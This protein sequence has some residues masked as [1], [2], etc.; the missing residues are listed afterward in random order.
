MAA[1]KATRPYMPGYG[2]PKGKK[3]LLPWSWAKQRL[4]TS[5]NYWVATT[6]PDGA[7]HVMVVWGLWLDGLFL[8]STGRQ[9][10]KARN[11]ARNR[12]CVICNE[13]A[14]Q[15]VVVEGIA[16]RVREHSRLRKFLSLYETKYNWDMSAF[17][18]DILLLKE[19]VFEVH[20]RVVFGL[21]EKKSLNSATRWKF[22][23]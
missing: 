11:L 2:L 8:F 6:R 23:D 9:S 5:H 14:H 3:G 22:A 4:E 18:K 21:S 12:K 17:E 20:P 1:P 13:L 15:A 16:R 10:R 19:P 7:P